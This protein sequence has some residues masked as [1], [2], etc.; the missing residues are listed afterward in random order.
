MF[1]EGPQSYKQAMSS[2]EKD[3]WETAIQDEYDGLMD[4]GT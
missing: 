4:M 1:Q 2:P 3:K